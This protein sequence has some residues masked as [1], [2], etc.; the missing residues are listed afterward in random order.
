V[1]QL[2]LGPTDK[3]TP[4]WEISACSQMRHLGCVSL[5]DERFFFFFFFLQTRRYV[6]LLLTFP[7]QPMHVVQLL[8][9][10]VVGVNI[11]YQ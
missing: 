7:G 4:P 10:A 2:L 5:D 3:A 11:Y 9:F 1:L 8:P 6:R